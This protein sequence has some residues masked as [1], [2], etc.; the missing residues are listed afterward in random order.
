MNA[1]TAQS[2]QLPYS[3]TSYPYLNL[4]FATGVIGFEGLYNYQLMALNPQE[5]ESLFWQLNCQDCEGLSFILFF[6]D[7]KLGNTLTITQEDLKLATQHLDVA[8]EELTVFLM[9]TTEKQEEHSTP[10]IT[11][12]L[13][14]PIVVHMATKQAWQIILPGADYSVAVPLINN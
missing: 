1:T 3:A 11:V 6:H 12:N 10:L 13:K 4:T 5:T 9:V 7:N 2:E 8:V 14:A